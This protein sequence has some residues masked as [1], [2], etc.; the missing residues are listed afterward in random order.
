MVDPA[1]ARKILENGLLSVQDILDVGLDPTMRSVTDAARARFEV[2]RRI[3]TGGAGDVFLA[4]DA[5]MDH[6]PRRRA[7]E[8]QD[9]PRSPR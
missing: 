9:P 2:V 4:H 6:G 5:A 3:G 8:D 7:E 1:F